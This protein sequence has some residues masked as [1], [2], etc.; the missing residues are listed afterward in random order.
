MKI[1]ITYTYL[2]DYFKYAKTKSGSTFPNMNKA[3]FSSINIL[4]PNQT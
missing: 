2:K 1:K 3:E 4:K